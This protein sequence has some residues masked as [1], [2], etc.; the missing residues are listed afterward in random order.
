MEVNYKLVV[1]DLEVIEFGKVE[2]N[3]S[4]RIYFKAI[5]DGIEADVTFEWLKILLSNNPYELN[6]DISKLKVS[7][8]DEIDAYIK[9]HNYVVKRHYT[10]EY[11]DN[12]CLCAVCDIPNT[13][14]DEEDRLPF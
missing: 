13:E 2:A 5:I 6:A 8:N 3:I 4:Q 14:T 1:S 9:K 12:L 10:F 11:T 7:M